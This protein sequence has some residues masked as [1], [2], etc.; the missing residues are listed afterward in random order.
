MKRFLGLAIVLVFILA[1]AAANASSS[2]LSLD[3]TQSSWAESELRQAYGYGLTLTGIMNN[4]KRDI[5]REEFSSLAV[6]LYEGLTGN[7][8]LVGANPFN[9]TKNTE[10]LKAY[11]L[12]IING[13]SPTSFYPIDKITRQEI[14]VMITRTLNVSGISTNSTDSSIPFSDRGQISSWALEAMQ[15]VYFN[16]IMKGIDSSSIGPLQNTSREQAIVLMKRTYEKYRGTTAV[17]Q[18][19]PLPTQPAQTVTT[20]PGTGVYIDTSQKDKGIV[21][22]GYKG[23]GTEKLKVMVAKG[24]TK[25]YYPLKPDG[26]IHG[27]PLQL[28]N[29]EY[30]VSVLNNISGNQYGYVK[31]ETLSINLKDPNIVYLNSIQTITW[32]PDS[33]ATKKNLQLVGNL[34]DTTGRI[35]ASYDFI[36]KNVTYNYD[37]INGLTSDYT[38]NPDETLRVLNGICYDYSSLFA[39]M[40]R[41][42]GIPIKLVKGYS[43]YTDV[44]HAWNEV[45]IN[46]K[47]VVVDTT[48]DSVYYSNRQ[49]Y[50][51]QKNSSDYT[52]VYEY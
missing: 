2:V 39:A 11:R 27:F 38:P 15:F 49:D 17:I 13:K 52:K 6:K 12:Q 51:F 36:V 47:W 8:A 24:E 4:Y 30:K 42:E 44:Y 45:F 5:T 20:V 50:T 23:N 3:G 32:T 41:S 22:V 48:F 21:R 43:R 29:G 10:V 25:Y 33:A 7:K 28:G 46:G 14:A 26:V 1:S 40:K 18:P 34:T 35:N 31:T 19:P 9:D 16:G 37:K